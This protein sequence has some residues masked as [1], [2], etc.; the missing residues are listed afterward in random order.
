MLC[1]AP[2]LRKQEAV[3]ITGLGRRSSTRAPCPTRRRARRTS[4]CPPPSN[5]TRDFFP[6][7]LHV[8][9]HPSRRVAVRAQRRQRRPRQGAAAQGQLRGDAG[10]GGAA[11]PQLLAA[12]HGRGGRTFRRRIYALKRSL[13]LS[14]W[15]C[16]WP[17]GR[18]MPC[19]SSF[20]GRGQANAELS[21]PAVVFAFAGSTC[22]RAER[23]SSRKRELELAPGPIPTRAM[24][25]A[26]ST[27]AKRPPPPS[28]SL[29]VS[30]CACGAVLCI[31]GGM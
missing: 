8:R 28:V 18:G 21:A 17:C 31:L 14:M 2:P 5:A 6:L 11:L 9:R 13:C 10:A 3:R 30:V 20:A 24:A 12:R 29:S 4:R 19:S 15:G 25:G 27:H 23:D 22:A 26:T 7:Q 16:V 1:C